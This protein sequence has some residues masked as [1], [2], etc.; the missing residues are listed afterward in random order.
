MKKT[1]IHFVKMHG[2]GNDFV[3]INALFNPLQLLPSQIAKL[4]DRHL[5]IGFDQ[6]LIIEAS[7]E[8]DFFCR[9]YNADG[10]EAEQCGNGLRSVA[11]FLHEEN[12][13]KR[14]SFS[15]ETLGGIFPLSIYDYDHI[16]ITMGIPKIDEK[17]FELKLDDKNTI[18]MSVISLGNPHAIVK[19]P[20]IAAIDIHELGAKI[21]THSFFN[22]GANVGFMEVMDKHHIQLR[23]FER[24]SGHTF[25]C[26]SNASAA[27]VAGVSNN[28]LSHQV[29]V[30]FAYGSLVIEW[31]GNAKS[32][33]HMT[34][35]A[36]RVFWGEI[37][38][39]L[40]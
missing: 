30:E 5:G 16:K 1:P 15:I 12:I 18:E 9:I 34:G 7:K 20:S 14:T 29:N 32:L 4:A 11:R 27:V 25:A 19:V 13:E 40:D 8:A 22:A 3:I 24:G 35:P 23:T 37:Y 21:S 31:D 33:V 6:L 36:T 38:L 10:S 17:L 28:W 39:P 2:L 26:G